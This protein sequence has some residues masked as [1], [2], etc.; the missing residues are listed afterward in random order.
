MS[1]STVY[2]EIYQML[3]PYL[4]PRVDVSSRLRLALLVTGLLQGQRAA[5]AAVAQALHQLGLSRATPE[6]I[7]RQLRRTENDPE[8]TAAW[9]VHP[10]ARERLLLGRPHELVL[11]LDPTTQEDRFVLL[12]VAV[13]YRGQALPLVWALWRANTPLTGK[14]F[15]ERVGD[16]LDT[17]A[18]LLPMGVPVTWLADRAFGTPAFVDQLTARGWH[19]VIRIQG[20]TRCRDRQGREQ[21]CSGLVS[22]R[23]P[24]AKLQGHVFKKMGWRSAAVIVYWGRPYRSPLCL[25]SD[26]G[27]RWS[28]ILLY[29]RRYGIETTF[30]DYKRQGWH[31]EQGQVSNPDHLE[32]WLIGMALASWVALA[33]GTQVASE[34]LAQA[35]TGH[36]H[37]VPWAGKRSLFTWG[38]HRLHRALGQAHAVHWA[39][40]FTDWTAPNWQRQLHA[41]HANAFIGESH[42]NCRCYSPARGT[43]TTSPVRP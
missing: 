20:Q 8:L 26:L 14:R 28:L 22:R 30:R 39:W 24:R 11:V 37:T 7:E 27:P 12:T 5:P 17:V 13:W 3:D 18:P 9:C 1:A 15:W 21:A 23:Q 40:T 16:L 19:Y 42:R 34:F 25:V 6:G 43:L 32:R 10:L 4:D 41:H 38:L 36:R 31:W 2:S 35:P 33:L 29:R